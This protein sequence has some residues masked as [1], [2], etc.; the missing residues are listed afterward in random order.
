MAAIGP[1]SAEESV[2]KIS[3]GCQRLKKA[4]AGAASWT[5]IRLIRVNL[6]RTRPPQSFVP[7]AP[8]S[9]YFSGLDGTHPASLVGVGA[10]RDLS[11]K[12]SF[13]LRQTAWSSARKVIA[14]NQRMLGA[15]SLPMNRAPVAAPGSK[16][17]FL[18]HDRMRAPKLHEPKDFMTARPFAYRGGLG[19]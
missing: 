5:K 1:I 10:S 19:P 2:P 3:A 14:H 18:A 6:V 17:H 13:E 9:P 11:E 8:R 7:Y 4:G 16:S 12:R 15:L